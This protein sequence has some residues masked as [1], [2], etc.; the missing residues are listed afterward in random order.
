MESG[1]KYA[2]VIIVGAGISG[3]VAA[4]CL[5]SRDSNLNVLVLEAASQIGGRTSGA[6][7]KIANDPCVTMLRFR[8]VLVTCDCELQ[9][10]RA[11]CAMH[12]DAS[13]VTMQR[14]VGSR[15]K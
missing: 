4:E 11:L 13:V 6:E 7:V 5:K 10:L 3:L 2:D 12:D 9:S 8:M 1:E 14:I 15:Q